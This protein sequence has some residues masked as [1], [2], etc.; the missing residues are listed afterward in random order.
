M[1]R[2]ALLLCLLSSISVVIGTSASPPY[3]HLAEL[4]GLIAMMVLPFGS[5]TSALRALHKGLSPDLLPIIAAPLPEVQPANG[6]THPVAVQS[7][8]KSFRS[9]PLF[10]ERCVLVIGNC[11]PLVSELIQAINQHR[12][13]KLVVVSHNEATSSQVKIALRELLPHEKVGQNG[14]RTFLPT[15]HFVSDNLQEVAQVQSLFKAYRPD[16][17]LH[18]VLDPDADK[19]DAVVLVQQRVLATAHILAAAQAEG[20]QQLLAITSVDAA[21]PRD[22]AALC[23]RI[24][25]QLVW[26]QAASG[27]GRYTVLRLGNLFTEATWLPSDLLRHIR[28]DGDWGDESHIYTPIPWEDA[29][30]GIIEAA[31]LQSHAS[32]I[33]PAL[34]QHISVRY[35]QSDSATVSD[36]EPETV[37]HATSQISVPDV[38]ALCSPGTL[39]RWLPES[40]LHV[41]NIVASTKPTLA[42]LI[43]LATAAAQNDAA[44]IVHLLYRCVSEASR[45]THYTPPEHIPAR[46]RFGMAERQFILLGGSAI[47]A[48]L[49]GLLAFQTAPLINNLVPRNDQSAWVLLCTVVWLVLAFVND[50]YSLEHV[51]RKRHTLQNLLFTS[52]GTAVLYLAI[53]FVLSLP[54]SLSIASFLTNFA[55]PPRLLVTLFLGFHTLLTIAWWMVYPRVFMNTTLRHRVLVVGAEPAARVLLDQV[56]QSTSAYEIVGFIDD[57]PALQGRTLQGIPI[58]GT[59]Y[60]L[61]A[62][63]ASTHADTI[64]LTMTH[65][66]PAPTLQALMDCYER[67]VKIKP[68]LLLYEEAMGRVAV[69]HLGQNWFPAPF[70]DTPGMK[71]F[72]SMLKRLFDIGMALLGAVVFLLLLPLVALAIRLDSPGTI[73]YCQDREGKGGKRFRMVKFRSMVQNAERAGKAEWATRNDPRI[74]RV[75]KFLRLTRI[76]EL[77]QVLNVLQGDM[78][79]VGPRPE[80]PEFVAQLQEQI[81]FY[82][83]RLSVKPGLTG[84]AQVRY[85]YGSSVEDALIKLQYDLYY[86]K[87]QSLLFDLLI[88][89]RTF[90]V[91]LGFKGT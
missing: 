65:D 77:P 37:L 83:A 32:V 60:D 58:L 42:D 22:V 72:Q 75:G 18:F 74:T 49:A 16:I 19:N 3:Q 23:E 68:L 80:R 10:H 21:N 86:I 70:W 87:H 45:V 4:L 53:Y 54:V 48:A 56:Q 43:A 27:A 61:T 24:A 25:E 17:V 57:K 35:A 13:R 9:M 29:V 1:G 26:Q 90:K 15:T 81:P 82:R 28:T 89:M 39:P 59:S 46:S 91:V 79:I 6:L 50:C 62:S 36:A 40:R 52:M 31:A 20:V 14:H 78:S 11:P 5:I 67:G 47:L 73:F 30:Q 66:V 69:E 12:P 38:A 2:T 8:S 51:H 85:R 76:D 33:V 88:V 41:A 63:V 64:V 44:Q 71:G 34:K 7:Q 55:D 84:W